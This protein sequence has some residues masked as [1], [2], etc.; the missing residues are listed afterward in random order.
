MCQL[1]IVPLRLRYRQLCLLKAGLNEILARRAD[2]AYLHQVRFIDPS[3]PCKGK[4]DEQLMARIL[5]LWDFLYPKF[6]PGLADSYRLRLDAA[7]LAIC[8]FAAGVGAR[9]VRQ[10]RIG[11]LV[12]NHG[13]AAARLTATL[14][15]IRRRATR[16]AVQVHGA[17]ACKEEENR[18][19]AFRL[20]IKAQML[21]PQPAAA[22][23]LS[24]HYKR[25]VQYAVDA[26]RDGLRSAGKRVPGEKRLRHLVRSALAAARRHRT[27]YSIRDLA[28]AP[29]EAAAFLT[30]WITVRFPKGKQRRRPTC[31]L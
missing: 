7:D 26:A 28:G 13:L 2:R 19:I 11:P 21:R 25:I 16:R 23:V 1:C 12:D 29:E 30:D 4:F 3:Q 17:Q 14:Q 9:L 5:K 10:K 22:N 18:W 15:N 27:T 20:W 6:E 24:Q 8:I 31:Q